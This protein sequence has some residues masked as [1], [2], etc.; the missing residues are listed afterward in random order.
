MKKIKTTNKQQEKAPMKD[1]TKILLYS[2]AGLIL[3]AIIVLISIENRSANITVRNKSDYKLEYIKAYFVDTEGR[4]SEDDIV[5]ENLESGDKAKLPLDK[6][7]L[8]YREANLELRFKFE[9]KDEMFVD[10]GY[11]ND[12]F[13]G[14]I[15]IDFDD[16]DDDRVN[17]KVKASTGL[18][19]SPYIDCNEEHIL[20][21][22][23]GEVEE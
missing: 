2:L 7:D 14:Q 20:N 15:S 17:L 3:L 1:S 21:L 4:I 13:E 22:A 19:P 12:V 8:L 6:I 5:F 9:D 18:L 10:S 11:F 16:I 23:T